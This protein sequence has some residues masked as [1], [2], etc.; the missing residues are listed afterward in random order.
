MR[1][2]AIEL[3][4]LLRPVA[5][6]RQY[7]HGMA[8]LGATACK[9]IDELLDAAV[10]IREVSSKEMKNPHSR[11]SRAVSGGGGRASGGFSIPF[12]PAASRIRR[13]STRSCEHRPRSDRGSSAG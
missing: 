13:R 6:E 8:A 12:D 9:L 3:G 10:G 5:T 2:V 7:F 4:K 11:P 1:V